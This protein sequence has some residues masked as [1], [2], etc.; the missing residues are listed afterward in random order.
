MIGIDGTRNYQRYDLYGSNESAA[1]IA[2]GNPTDNGW[3]LIA[4]VATDNAWTPALVDQYQTTAASVSGINANYRYLLFD[5]HVQ[6]VGGLGAYNGNHYVE[7]DV[8]VP[9]P[10]TT[11]LLATGAVGL[12]AYAWR[13]RK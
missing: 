5:A 9:E 3:T 13:K 12:L 8:V 1:P 11:L 6:D 2:T 4:N 10:S 7:L